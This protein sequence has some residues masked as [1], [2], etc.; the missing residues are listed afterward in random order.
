[1]RWS[2]VCAVSTVMI[3]LLVGMLISGSI[4]DVLYVANP[5]FP[6]VNALSSYVT[7]KLIVFTPDGRRIVEL[8]PL[9]KNFFVLVANYFLGQLAF[10]HD[11][12]IAESGSKYS[13]IY[14]YTTD[15]YGNEYSHPPS[16]EICVGNG[17]GTASYLDTKLFSEVSCQ[18]LSASNVA[19]NDTGTEI[20]I[21][22]RTVFNFTSPINITEAGLVLYSSY[23]HDSVLIA[24]D[25][26][27]PVLANTSIGIEY[28]ITIDY[29]KP[30]FTKAFWELVAN[31]YLGLGSAGL[32]FTDV[33]NVDLSTPS[34]LLIGINNGSAISWSPT[35]SVSNV[36]YLTKPISQYFSCS[37][38][39][40]EVTVNYSPAG[41]TIAYGLVIE[42]RVDTNIVM[43][44][45]AISY[46]NI[47]I[48]YIPFSSA[49]T[50]D[51]T[52]YVTVVLRVEVA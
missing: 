51:P 26:F 28:I 5:H 9:T 20:V 27:P 10:T 7:A 18:T 29:S 13:T 35:V 49:T 33:P 23:Y 14:S 47:L 15:S 42:L 24:H 17:T 31:N 1:M 52:K 6:S 4:S 45:Q 36:T 30:P 16:I 37:S 34:S 25:T 44:S 11:Y 8:D 41:S 48:A 39:G 19:V 32:G 3:A 46:T 12:V 2:V 40:F 50:L 43:T 22:Y 21:Y 38:G